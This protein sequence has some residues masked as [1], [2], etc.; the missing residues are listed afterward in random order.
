MVFLYTV[1]TMGKSITGTRRANTNGV[2]RTIRHFMSDF[3]KH[4]ESTFWDGME[5]AVMLLMREM[6]D[7]D[8]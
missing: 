1:G 3:Y 7:H 5:K 4:A 8:T 6:S 2:S